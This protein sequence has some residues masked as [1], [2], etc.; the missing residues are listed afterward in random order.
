MTIFK[1][2]SS[3]AL[4]VIGIFGLAF[5]N[6]SYKWAAVAPSAPTDAALNQVRAIVSQW[7]LASVSWL[8]ILVGGI[9][10]LTLLYDLAR[11]KIYQS[12]IIQFPSLFLLDALAPLNRQL[13][14]R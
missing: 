7:F 10:F 12:L 14:L 11:Q 4:L 13:N 6:L 8:A 1:D 5:W 9:L 2:N 3:K